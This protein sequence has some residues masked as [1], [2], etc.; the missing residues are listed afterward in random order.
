MVSILKLYCNDRI[1][2]GGVYFIFFDLNLYIRCELIFQNSSIH[3][4]NS[5]LKGLKVRKNEIFFCSDL[6]F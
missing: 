2:F 3:L 1:K 4:A 5:L 6:D